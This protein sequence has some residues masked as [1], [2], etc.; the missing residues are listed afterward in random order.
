MQCRDFQSKVSVKST[1]DKA[2]PGPDGNEIPI[3]I[4]HPDDAKPRR[5]GLPI[6][7]YFHGGCFFMGSISTHDDL[8]RNLGHLSAYIVISVDYRCLLTTLMFAAML[9]TSLIYGLLLH[10]DCMHCLQCC[11]DQQAFAVS[12]LACRH[13]QLLKYMAHRFICHCSNIA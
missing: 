9:L 11:L 1:A 2:I 4:Y 7:V 6:L 12:G 10:T 8:C 13:G 3:R 5:Q